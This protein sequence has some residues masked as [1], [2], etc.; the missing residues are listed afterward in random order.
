MTHLTAIVLTYN[1]AQQIRECLDSLR[2]ADRILVFDSHSTD[3][4]VAI[5]N[6][7]GADVIRH[8]FLNYAAQRNAALDAVTAQTDWVLFVDADERISRELATEIRDKLKAPDVSAWNLPRHNYIFGLLTKGAGWYPDYQTRLLRIGRARFD[9]TR[10]VHE[11]VQAEGNIGTCDNAIL[12][13]NY[14]D[15]AH[16]HEKQT[17]YVEFDAQI[18][19]EQGVKPR[20]HN[21]ILQPL[22]HFVWRFITLGGYQDRCH[23]LKLSLLMALYEYRKYRLLAAKVRQK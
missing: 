17:R 3:S 16:F 6:D 9:P 14:R 8:P 20:F 2:F 21:F 15:L 12:H 19:L 11:V 7:T 23:G 22:R 10:K 13:F 5:A 4:T 18:L 1:E